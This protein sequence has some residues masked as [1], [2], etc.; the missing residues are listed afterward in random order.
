A[1]ESIE[2]RRPRVAERLWR[3][4]R[5]QGRQAMWTAGVGLALALALLVTVLSWGA[6]RES[7]KGELELTTD[8]PSLTAEVLRDDDSLVSRF[9]VPTV[10]PVRLDPGTYRLR[11][12]AP[13]W[14][15]EE[16]NLLILPGGKHAFDADLLPRELWPA[17]ERIDR[18]GPDGHLAPIPVVLADRTDLLLVQDNGIVRVHGKTGEQ[19]PAA[20]PFEVINPL[21]NSWPDE[22]RHDLLGDGQTDVIVS[23]GQG[24][25]YSW[26][27][28]GWHELRPAT[29]AQRRAPIAYLPAEGKRP[30]AVSLIGQ[31]GKFSLERFTGEGKLVWQVSLP[32]GPSSD[33]QVP[34]RAVLGKWNGQP[35]LVVATD[36]GVACVEPATGKMLAVHEAHLL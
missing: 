7:Q 29:S 18:N 26:R 33:R 22:F 16:A 13:G 8:G 11:L 12:S 27:K 1:D 20:R 2:A 6:Y 25:T 10:D 21:P 30:D 3:R 9:R 28:T 24:G 5:K 4:A 35:A 32:T 23:N 17:I 31:A 36:V 15:S 19:T 34:P 14:P